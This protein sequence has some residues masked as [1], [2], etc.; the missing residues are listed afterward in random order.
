MDLT[1]AT[2]LVRRADASNGLPVMREVRLPVEEVRPGETVLVGPGE[3]LP[4]DGVVLQGTSSIDQSSITGES[5]PVDVEPGAEV[6]AGT[7]NGPG[8]LSIRTER[9]AKDTTLARIIEMVEQ[10]QSR[11][12][13]SQQFVDRFSAVYTPVVIVSAALVAVVPAWFFAQPFNDWF[14]RALVLLVVACPC[15]LVIST[16]VSIVS[17]IGAATRRGVLVKGGATLEALSKVKAVAFDK[18][19]TLTEG[20]PRV[21]DVHA[22]DADV[23]SLL[24]LAATVEARSEHPLAM[25]IVHAGRN[26]KAGAPEAT[27]FT[28]FPGLGAKAWVDGREVYVGNARLFRE[29]G[30]PTGDV[31]SLLEDEQAQGRTVV[32]VGTREGALGTISLAD[33]LRHDARQTVG[34]LREAGISYVAMLTGD[35]ERTAGAIARAVGVDEYYA[36][37]L[38]ADKLGAVERITKQRGPVAMVGDGVNDAP[39]LA[40][41]QV[42]IA[43]GVAGTDAALEVADVAL[44]SDDLS[45]L[46][47]AL[48]LSRRTLST[49]Q[50]NVAA[51]LIV[52]AV[53][54]VLAALGMLPLWGA[55]FA[56]MGVSLLVTLNGMRLLGYGRRGA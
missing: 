11:R 56:D 3:R 39:A 4:L 17:A 19:G 29:Q 35:N 43:M 51:S 48:L 42:G 6:F 18:T 30:I 37:L 7:I 34:S 26:L 52:K 28:A 9:A 8:A 27:Q 49:I 47:Y 23:D 33:S 41:A 1:P 44:M 5:V 22:L 38:P 2:A 36:G 53:A 13:P 54:L 20:R 50:A 21:V 24:R 32:V 14:Y 46:N 40:A 31:D 25:A 15:A 12:A 55:I 45:R 16:P 10:A